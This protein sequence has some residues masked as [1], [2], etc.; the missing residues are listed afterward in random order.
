MRFILVDPNPDPDPEPKATK[1]SESESLLP[2]VN[3][4]PVTKG[5]KGGVGGTEED[6]DDAPCPFPCINPEAKDFFRFGSLSLSLVPSLLP[7][8]KLGLS[9]SLLLSLEDSRESG[10]ELEYE[11]LSLSNPP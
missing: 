7:L 9:L 4:D 5:G 8:D 10:L 2:Q 1:S 3:D 11:C 6:E